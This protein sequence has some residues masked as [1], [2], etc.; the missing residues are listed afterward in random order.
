M[1]KANKQIDEIDIIAE[2]QGKAIKRFN[3]I[4]P[5]GPKSRKAA[6]RMVFGTGFYRAWC[7]PGK[8]YIWETGIL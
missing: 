6:S 5:Q 7:S 2:K 3:E 8:K 1:R 4:R